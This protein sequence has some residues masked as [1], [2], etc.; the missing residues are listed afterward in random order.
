MTDHSPMDYYAKRA[1]Q[2]E[3]RAKT[4]SDPAV[5][6]VHRQMADTYRHIVESGEIPEPRARLT[7][8]PTRA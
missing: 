2:E 8:A 6:L 3:E 1:G 5:R 4:A 7:L